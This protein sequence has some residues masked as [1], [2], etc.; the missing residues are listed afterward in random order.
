V[1]STLPLLFTWIVVAA[2]L[3]LIAS[4]YLGHAS[5]PYDMCT[6]GDGRQIPCAVLRKTSP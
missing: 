3:L 4:T 5:S 2:L 6:R 1:R